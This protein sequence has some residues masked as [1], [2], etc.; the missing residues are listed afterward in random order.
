MSSGNQTL[1]TCTTGHPNSG[2]T[3]LIHLSLVEGIT[4]LLQL[5]SVRPL[6]SHRLIPLNTRLH[7]LHYTTLSLC[8]RSLDHRSRAGYPDL[9]K[10]SKE[11]I[12]SGS[13]Q[14]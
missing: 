13:R 9:L 11:R 5:L 10:L 8:P 7:S 12:E 14:R 2:N 1:L 3:L 4:L 6:S